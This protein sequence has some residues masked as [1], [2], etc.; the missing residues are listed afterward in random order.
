[1]FDLNIF[2]RSPTSAIITKLVQANATIQ[3]IDINGGFYSS[4]NQFKQIFYYMEKDCYLNS[5]G[6]TSR[7]NYINYW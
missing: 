1:M 6:I 2:S 3:K 5:L 7:Y 4:D